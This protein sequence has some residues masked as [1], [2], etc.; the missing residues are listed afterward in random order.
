MKRF[1][2]CSILLVNA[3][4]ILLIPKSAKSSHLSGGNFEWQCVGQDSFMITLKLFRDCSGVSA[5]GPNLNIQFTSPCG[6]LN[7]TLSQIGSSGVEVSQLCPPQIPFS[8]C[9]NGSLPGMEEY[10]YQGIVH[11]TPPCSLW[12]M[13]YQICCRNNNNIGNMTGSQFRIEAQLNNQSSSAINASISGTDPTCA[14]SCDGSVTVT[15]SGGIAPYTFE[16]PNNTQDVQVFPT[17]ANATS[18]RSGLCAG[19]HIVT[20]T[21]ANSCSVEK[22]IELNSPPRLIANGF[23]LNSDCGTNCSGKAQVK[24]SGGSAPFTLQGAGQ[25][26]NTSQSLVEVSALCAGNHNFTVTDNNGCQDSIQIPIG[27]GGNISLNFNTLQNGCA[28]SCNAS[29]QVNASGGAAPYSYRWNSGSDQQTAN[30][31]CPG[32]YKLTVTDAGGCSAVDSVTIGA[33]DTL[34]INES[35]SSTLCN[36]CNGSIDA[37]NV[38]GGAAPYTYV[39]DISPS[40]GNTPQLNNL[41]QGMYK[42]TVTDANGCSLE[43]TFGI[44]TTPNGTTGPNAST[45]QVVDETCPGACDGSLTVTPGGGSAP[46]SYQWSTGNPAD[47]NDTLTNL[48]AGKY[49]VEITDATGCKFVYQ[50]EVKPVDDFKIKAS[51]LTAGCGACRGIASVNIQG[52]DTSNYN[53]LWSNAQ[54]NSE[55]SGLCPGSYW[56]QVTGPGNCTLTDTVVIDSVSSNINLSFSATAKSCYNSCDGSAQLMV[57]G[58]NSPY[59]VIW[60]NGDTGLVRTDLCSDTSEITIIDASGC[61]LDTTVILPASA[62]TPISPANVSITDTDCGSS[63]GS[64]TVGNVTGGTP[65]FQYRWNNGPITGSNSANNL[66]PGVNRLIIFDAN[67]CSD[68]TYHEVENTGAPNF[69]GTCPGNNSP[70]FAAQPIPYVCAGQPVNFSP[71]VTE[72]DG[73]SL[74]YSVIQPVNGNYTPGNPTH[75]FNLGPT[76][77]TFNSSNGQMTF[78]PTLAMVNSGPSHVV[79]IE[80]CEYRNGALLGCVSREFQFVIQNCQNIVPAMTSGGITNF[81]GTATLTDSNEVTACVGDVINFDVIFEDSLHPNQTYGDNITITS[82]A[83]SVFPGASVNTTSG[84]TATFSFSWVATQGNSNR[85]TF[86]I[87]IEDDACPVPGIGSYSFDIRTIPSTFVPDDTLCGFNDTVNLHVTGGDTFSWRVISGDSMIFGQNFSDTTGTLGEHVWVNPTQTT[88]YEVTSNLS[89]LCKNID[90]VTVFVKTIDVG[91]DTML[92]R[93]DT[94]TLGATGMIP[95]PNGTDSYFWS[96]TTGLDNPNSLNPTL[97]VGDFQ[98]STLYT[99]IYDD[100]CGCQIADS[101]LVEVSEITVDSVTWDKPVCGDSNATLE[102]HASGGFGNFAYSL[103]STGVY[104]SSSVF[105]NLSIGYYEAW[106]T[107]SLGCVSLGVKDTIL[108]PGVPE[109]VRDSI[110]ISDVTCFGAQNGSI[111]VYATGGAPPLQ[112]SIDTGNTYQ[113][114]PLFQNLE[115]DTYSIEVTDDFGCQT[116]PVEVVVNTNDAL[117]LDSAITRDL[118]CFGNNGGRIEVFGRGGTNPLEYTIDN[119]NTWQTNNSLFDSIPADNYVVI[120]RD[121]FG[122]T[123]D[124]E[125]VVIS[126]PDELLANLTISHDTC[127]EACGGRAAANVTGGTPPYTFDWNGYGANSNQSWNLCAGPNY[128]FDITDDNGCLTEVPFN[129]TQP[130]ELVIDS[131]INSNLSCNGNKDGQITIHPKGGKRPYAYSIDGGQNFN[132]SNNFT[133]LEAG[134]YNIIVRDSAHRCEV[135]DEVLLIEPDPVILTT[136]FSESTICVSNCINLSAS[137]TGGTGSTYEYIWTGISSTGSV[138]SVCPGQDT[139]YAVYAED[140]NGCVSNV[141]IFEIKL[142]DSLRVTTEKETEICPGDTVFLSAIGE[143]G[144]GQG[145]RFEWTPLLGLSSGVGQSINAYPSASTIYTVRLSDACGSPTVTDTIRVNVRE[146]PEIDFTVSDSVAGCEPFTTTLINQTEPVQFVRW[147]IGDFSTTGFSVDMLDM[148]PGEYDVTM[149]ITTPEGC[150]GQLTKRNYLRVFRTPEANFYMDPNPTTIFNTNIQFRNQS[151]TD[152]VDW[153]WD[154]A[155]QDSSFESSP[156]FMMA[157]DTGKFPIHLRVENRHKCW[158]E[159]TKELIIGSEYNLF[160]PNAFTPNADGLNDVFAPVALGVNDKDYSLQIFNR[161][162]QIIFE[163]NSLSIPWDGRIQ[164]TGEPAPGG[165][166]VWKIIANDNTV[167]QELHEKMGSVT[168]IR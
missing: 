88:T 111:E 97:T 69:G 53:I 67:G 79:V 22:V 166:Y 155:G 32:V 142:H 121:S 64:V 63:N 139:T 62:S 61:V 25:T 18:T 128:V 124:P 21:D 81:T 96:P 71:A 101:F 82:N 56:V 132:P 15:T 148:S 44:N 140:V 106:A 151:S 77:Y 123:T 16:W 131:I 31:L 23:E 168:L 19:T 129:I 80:V 135:I 89:N 164:S 47:T 117:F 103:D 113:L 8:S 150:E 100:G 149:Y 49:A 59:T 105:Q 55:I 33:P 167:E 102:V 119:G 141:E 43:K 147:D 158:D 58:G 137:A 104:D 26:I 10:T 126:Q 29:V 48:C 93:G 108:D 13:G 27:S 75:P 73:D 20:I 156:R 68:T 161:W 6:T 84:N 85:R 115:P 112:Y 163:S 42:L 160:V 109:I 9:G 99:L 54:T 92:C 34:D 30:D 145:Y 65:P 78:T 90:T 36:T 91:P 98:T 7:A 40:P 127:F 114:N 57:I 120:V 165:V 45:I 116:L 144:N 46:Y 162:G 52:N 38:T 70:V 83:Q 2:I 37:S 152:V 130:D 51:G 66:E 136:P 87:D 157:S 107:D 41:C 153:E 133:G 4:F 72:P 39:W 122:C 110:D 50:E 125:P 159:I 143:G 86:T 138:Q 3:I 12:T 94:M 95:C 118:D 5:P 76:A 74:V 1:K 24:I 154:F 17:G 35:I 11:L 14:N 146:I 60:N 134:R 28:D